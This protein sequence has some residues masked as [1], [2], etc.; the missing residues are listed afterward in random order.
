MASLVLFE[1]EKDSI[2]SR[3]LMIMGS[4]STIENVEARSIQKK[5]LNMYP[6]LTMDI[7]MISIMKAMK[8]VSIKY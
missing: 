2:P 6:D 3:S 8:Q 7:K 1:E 4:S 5:K